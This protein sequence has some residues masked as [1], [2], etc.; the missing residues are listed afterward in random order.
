MKPALSVTAYLAA[1]W[2]A[3]F[4]DLL[5]QQN[6]QLSKHVLKTTVSQVMEEMDRSDGSLALDRASKHIFESPSTTMLLQFSSL[7]KF[8]DHWI[9]V[10][11]A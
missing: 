8:R 5:T 11:F 1:E 4:I 6:L 3:E 7:A 9:A 10:A 2:A